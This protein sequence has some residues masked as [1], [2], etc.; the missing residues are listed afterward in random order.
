MANDYTYPQAKET[1]PNYT[2]VYVLGPLLGGFLA[3]VFQKLI[4][5]FAIK[6]AEEASNEEYG[7]MVA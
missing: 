6:H 4:Y 2:V 5:E 3:G 7:K 1:Q